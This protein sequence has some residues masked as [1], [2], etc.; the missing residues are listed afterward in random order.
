MNL[1]LP[2]ISL[3]SKFSKKIREKEPELENCRKSPKQP[4][5]KKLVHHAPLSP[6]P[7]SA[8]WLPSVLAADPLR[9][10]GHRRRCTIRATLRRRTRRRHRVNYNTTPIDFKSPAFAVWRVP[11]V[12]IAHFPSLVA[13]QP[14]P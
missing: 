11:P 14:S 7:S 4:V 13:A 10:S 3:M 8:A 6:P 5:S 9:D 2:K 12:S 1:R